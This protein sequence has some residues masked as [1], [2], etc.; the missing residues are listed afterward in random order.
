VV[1]FMVTHKYDTKSLIFITLLFV[2]KPKYLQHKNNT[3]EIKWHIQYY[4]INKVNKI[5]LNK[6]TQILQYNLWKSDL[7]MS[8]IN[9]VN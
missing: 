4:T 5:I 2:L 7:K 9:N 3:R 8:V 6:N 1:A